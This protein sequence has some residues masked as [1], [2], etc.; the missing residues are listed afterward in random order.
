ERARQQRER[1]PT[2]GYSSRHGCDWEELFAQLWHAQN[3]KCYLCGEALDRDKYR[4]IHLDHDHSCCPLGKSCEACRRGLACWR[5]N[6]LIG[7]VDDD[8]KLLRRIADNL[9]V[10]NALVRERMKEA[11]LTKR[12]VLF[13]LD[14]AW[15]RVVLAERLDSHPAEFPVIQGLVR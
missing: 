1:W 8:P 2:R 9:Q 14:E 4:G 5:C 11:D 3:G 7:R 10:A 6:I 12:G 13:D 15:L